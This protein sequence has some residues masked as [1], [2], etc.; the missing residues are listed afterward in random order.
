M[1]NCLL[2]VSFP[3]PRKAR[4][5]SRPCSFW[6]VRQ[7]NEFHT[8]GIRVNSQHFYIL[9]VFI[10]FKVSVTIGLSSSLLTVRYHRLFD[11]KKNLFIN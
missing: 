10:F 8:F 5:L 9:F 3:F 11:A 2:G 1:V 7:N 4:K 6:W